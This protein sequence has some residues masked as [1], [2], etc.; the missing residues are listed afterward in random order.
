MDELK[1]TIQFPVIDVSN[2]NFK[3]VLIDNLDWEKRT[4]VVHGCVRFKV[5]LIWNVVT[6]CRLN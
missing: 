4:I 5:I 6:R 1:K 2:K 3:I